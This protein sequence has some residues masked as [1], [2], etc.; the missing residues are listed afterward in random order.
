M[1][2]YKT[3]ATRKGSESTKAGNIRN[4]FDLNLILPIS[5]MLDSSLAFLGTN[6]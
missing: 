2:N 3:F 4:I 5:E 6:Q 1:K